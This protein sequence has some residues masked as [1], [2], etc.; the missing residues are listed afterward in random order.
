MDITDNHF[1]L[2]PAGQKEKAVKSFLKSGGT[3]LVLVHK[4][5]SPWNKIDQFK[6]QVRTTLRLSEKARDV[7]AKVAVICS[8]HPVQLVKLLELYDSKKACEIYLQAV[9]FCT[10]LVDERKIMGLGELGRPHFEVNEKIWNLS[11]DILQESLLRA[12]EVD[13]SVILHT[14]TGTPEVMADL[15]NIASKVGF[16]KSR[17]VKHYGGIGSVANSY[18][19]TVSLLAS[20]ENITFA[21]KNNHSFM[22]ET[23]YL[24]DPNRPGAVLGPKT[25]PRKTI[26]LFEEGVIDEEQFSKIHTD[27]PDFIYKEFI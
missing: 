14:E 24:D 21:S 10:S 2:D 6:T 25:V 12:K 5:Y 3:R 9:D 17:L 27:L 22:L 23:D 16:P 1:H 11:N 20:N 18:G 19:L 13:S 8:P 4:P 7:G 15:A 26:K